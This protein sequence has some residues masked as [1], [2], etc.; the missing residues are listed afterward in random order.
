MP[1]R[2]AVFQLSHEGKFVPLRHQSKSRLGCSLQFE[3][4]EIR[5]L[6]ATFVVT[7]TADAGAGTLR[8]AVQMANVMP[9]ADVIE[10]DATIHGSSIALF[11]GDLE[12]TDGLSVIGPG[13]DLLTID[14]SNR[15]RIFRVSVSTGGDVE[16]S[17]VT[18]TGG[19]AYGA[20]GAI[21]SLLRPSYTMT[22]SDV[23]I[24]G[25]RTS[26]TNGQGG[27]IY[28]LGPLHM[29][30]CIVAG[31]ST[32]GPLSL[33]GAISGKTQITIEDCHVTNNA[34]LGDGSTGGAIGTDSASVHLIDSLVEN[35]RTRGLAAAGG[36]VFTEEDL[37]VERSTL[38]DNFT[39]DDDSPGGAAYAGLVTVMDS[40]VSENYTGGDNSPGGG[41]YAANYA[42]IQQST[43]SSNRTFGANSAGGGLAADQVATIKASTVVQNEISGGQ[44]GGGIAVLDGGLTL[45]GAIV[46]ENQSLATPLPLD[47]DLFAS[48]GI[49]A[50]ASMIG[51]LTLT[52]LTEAPVGMPDANGNLVGDPNGLGV[53]D[54][55]LGPLQI[56]GGPTPTHRLLPTSPAIN[57]GAVLVNPHDQRGAPFAR[58]VN[59]QA[60]MGAYEVQ[61]GPGHF[62]DGI[63]DCSDIDAVVAQI[64]SGSFDLAFDFSGDGL[65]DIR[66]VAAWLAEAG[67]AQLPSGNAYLFGDAN[68][69]GVVD[70]Q[71]FVVWNSNKF[72]ASAAWCDGDFDANGL[73]DGIDFVV[74]NSNKFQTADQRTTADDTLEKKSALEKNNAGEGMPTGIELDRSVSRTP[75]SAPAA[76]SVRIAPVDFIQQDRQ[77]DEARPRNERSNL[78]ALVFAVDSDAYW[79]HG[80]NGR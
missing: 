27:A 32:L 50:D 54:P 38:V 78:N 71:D 4:L 64:A 34:T 53:I 79:S 29:S 72:T 41:L 19:Y 14:G 6:L 8:E 12:V 30:D 36:A 76:I 11:S 49:M 45:V 65:L 70:A 42:S 28:N 80:V 7:S 5:N 40:T 75:M 10:F 33:G 25:N 55:Q 18:L 77:E 74:W 23:V 20:G 37:T 48:A 68:L 63:Y 66:D 51:S 16:F 13:P 46:A 61:T 44:Q 67:H 35:N 62:G 26:G 59:G 73:V 17:G 24:E 31:N 56:N 43:I 52:N 69:D 22:L 9:G 15:S 3:S 57:A 39:Y 58:T 2:S 1:K 47:Q 21:A 60:D